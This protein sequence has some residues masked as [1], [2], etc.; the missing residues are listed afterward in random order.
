MIV[1]LNLGN[2]NLK[3]HAGHF[4][5]VFWYDHEKIAIFKMGLGG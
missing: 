5:F 2:I 4:S 1:A 3:S